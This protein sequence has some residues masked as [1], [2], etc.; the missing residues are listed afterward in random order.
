MDILPD[1]D[2]DIDYTP[3]EG[4]KC[5]DKR[6]WHRASQ[7]FE[8]IFST[9]LHYWADLINIKDN[10]FDLYGNRHMEIHYDPDE[11][12]DDEWVKSSKEVDNEMDNS[13]DGEIALNIILEKIDK[14]IEEQ[15]NK[16][17]IVWLNDID[18]NWEHIHIFFGTDEELEEITKKIL[19]K[20][21]K[22][23][24]HG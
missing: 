4:I 23:K 13:I 7:S 17:P 3:W 22:E 21:R 6:G 14:Q 24:E 20:F 19:Q 16:R 18:N 9:V 2:D 15:A 5:F 11:L 1:E 8:S 10:I 12:T